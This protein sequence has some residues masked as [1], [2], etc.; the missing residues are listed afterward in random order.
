MAAGVLKLVIPIAEE[1]PVAPAVPRAESIQDRRHL[2]DE[3]RGHASQPPAADDL[4][5]AA[6]LFSPE[7]SQQSRIAAPLFR[8]ARSSDRPRG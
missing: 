6:L 5:G 7:L 4:L 1:E 2:A 8:E 3:L